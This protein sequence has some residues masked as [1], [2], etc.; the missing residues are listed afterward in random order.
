MCYSAMHG[1]VTLPA[2]HAHPH[3]WVGLMNL[4]CAHSRCVSARTQTT[5]MAEG[6]VTPAKCELG[7]SCL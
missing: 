1:Y 4:I 5:K 3:G 2:T 6:G 7:V